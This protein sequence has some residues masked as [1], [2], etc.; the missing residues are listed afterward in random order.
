MKRPRYSTDCQEVGGGGDW[1][2]NCDAERPCL[3]VNVCRSATS[4]LPL[5]LFARLRAAFVLSQ[6]RWIFFVPSRF[7]HLFISLARVI[8]AEFQ[9]SSWGTGV[10]LLPWWYCISRNAIW[11]RSHILFQFTCA[12][13]NRAADSNETLTRLKRILHSKLRNSIK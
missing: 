1:G 7:I 5:S 11:R 8:R 9:S 13:S 4:P 6:I 3:T 2:R 10:C 12:Y